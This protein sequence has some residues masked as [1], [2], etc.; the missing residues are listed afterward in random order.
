MTTLY[1]ITA[2]YKNAFNS[3]DELGFS[4]D[5]I[6][7]SLSVIEGELVDKCKNVAYYREDLLLVAEAKKA[8]AKKLNEEASAITK[9]ANSMLEYLDTNMRLSGITEIDCDYFNIKYQKNPPS[10]A[11]YDEADIPAE[12]FKEKTTRSVDKIALKKA[13]NDGLVCKGAEMVQGERLVIK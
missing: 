4:P 1:N 2:E 12:F 8:L 11:V 5:E 7:D 3:L 10:V 6:R 9:K 13:L